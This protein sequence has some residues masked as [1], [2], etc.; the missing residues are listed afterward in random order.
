VIAV[1]S[2][3][4]G[5]VSRERKIVRPDFRRYRYRFS[6]SRMIALMR[7]STLK[8]PGKQLSGLGADVQKH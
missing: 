2:K 7:V 6:R 5:S 8:T 3:N 4:K 1:G